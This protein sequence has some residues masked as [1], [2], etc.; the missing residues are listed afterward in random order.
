MR[1]MGGGGGGRIERHN[2]RV[3]RSLWG[4]G[5]GSIGGDAGYIGEAV[6]VGWGGKGYIERG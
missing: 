4:R 5:G 6:S 2:G 3:W 1:S